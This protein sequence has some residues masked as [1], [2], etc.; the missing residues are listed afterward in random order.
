MTKAATVTEAVKE[1]LIGSEEPVHQLSAQV[2]ARF[3]SYAVKD[4]DTGELYMGAEQFIDAIAPPD[5]DY[6]SE[7]ANAT[8]AIC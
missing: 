5:E 6:V 1:S 8:T 2:K 7:G 4:V 3:N